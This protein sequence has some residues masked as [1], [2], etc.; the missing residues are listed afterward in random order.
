MYYPCGTYFINITFRGTSMNILYYDDYLS[1][2]LYGCAITFE[3]VHFTFHIGVITGLKYC[4]VR[5]GL[6]FDF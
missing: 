1:S 2:A 3:K 4:S 6:E 5:T